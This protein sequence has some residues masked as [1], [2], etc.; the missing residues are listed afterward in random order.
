[1]LSHGFLKNSIDKKYIKNVLEKINEIYSSEISLK[2]TYFDNLNVKIPMVNKLINEKLEKEIKSLLGNDFITLEQVEMHILLK[3]GDPIPHHQD[4]FY[5]CISPDESLKIL[6]PLNKLDKFSG[7]LGFLD[8]NHKFKT[9]NHNAS[10]VKNFSA[11]IEEKDYKNLKNKYTFYD[12]DIGDSSYHFV[13]SV[14]FSNGNKSNEDKYFLV[15]RFQCLNAKRSI[16]DQ[17]K[18]ELVRKIHLSKLSK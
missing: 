9:L 14:H 15:F 2:K 10:S 16:E 6:V 18:Y 7:A 17:K 1:M 12:Y 5:H 3:N 11:Y 4:N 8:C 13:S